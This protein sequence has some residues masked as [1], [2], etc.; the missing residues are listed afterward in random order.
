MAKLQLVVVTHERKVLEVECDEVVV[1]GREGELGILPGHAAFVGSL[2]PGVLQVTGGESGT[3][4]VS[5]G[6][7]EVSDDLMTVLTERAVSKGD[8]D[9]G[10]VEKELEEA[11]RRLERAEPEDLTKL[12]DAVAWA[13][14]RLALA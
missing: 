11:S 9:R 4:A 1:P 5:S 10:A 12:Q 2:R 7:C 6:F 3:W 14:A 8:V 13:E